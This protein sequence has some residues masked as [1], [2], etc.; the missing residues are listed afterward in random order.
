MKKKE[1][2]VA[3]VELSK[4]MELLSEEANKACDL[5]DSKN[6]EISELRTVLED[7][8]LEN[9]VL[10]GKLQQVERKVINSE[11]V[12]QDI[13]K[14]YDTTQ[15]SIGIEEIRDFNGRAVVVKFEDGTK[16]RA[17]VSKKEK[18][19]FDKGIGV[20]ICLAKKILGTNDLSK[21]VDRMQ[22]DRELLQ[23]YSD[24]TSPVREKRIAALEAWNEYPKNVTQSFKD[25]YVSKIRK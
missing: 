2:K 25:R 10:K 11:S 18:R 19:R 3:L 23:T 13:V 21:T 20:A 24:L 8:A 1:Y 22:S 15:K 16:V 7:Y 14:A 17:S 9:S 12:M 4:K 5:I 6:R